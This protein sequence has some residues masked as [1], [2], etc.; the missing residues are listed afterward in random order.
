M[1]KTPPSFNPTSVHA[2]RRGGWLGFALLVLCTQHEAAA[3]GDDARQRR[4]MVEEITSM[5]RVGGA[6]RIDA[7]VLAVMA[8]VPRHEFVPAGQKL[9]AY[10]NRPLPIRHGKRLRE[11]RKI[12]D[13]LVY[14][15]SPCG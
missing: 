5:A 11:I 12:N 8:K 7:R 2:T 14:R 10:D 4:Q 6:P 9:Y 15:C 13:L 1:N 3:Q